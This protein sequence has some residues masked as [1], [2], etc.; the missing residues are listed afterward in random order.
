MSP[1]TDERPTRVELFIG[2]GG[3]GKTTVAC[4]TA[5]AHAAAGERVLLA[6]IDQAHSLADALGV[7][8]AHDPGTVAGIESVTDRVDVIEIDSLALL[9]DRFQGLTATLV[10]GAGHEHGFALDALDPAELTG[11]PGAQELLALN[12]VEVL[13]NE[14][15]WHTIVVDCGPS[16]DLLRTLSAPEMLLGYLERL[17]PRYER[18]AA[19]GRSDPRVAVVAA[20][21]ER[22]VADVEAVKALLGDRGRTTA[23]LVTAPERVALAEAA[24]TRSAA[25]LLGLRLAAVVV[26]KALPQLGKD[27]AGRDADPAAR[28]YRDRRREQLDVVADLD[29]QLA[30]MPVVVVGHTGPEPVGLARLGELTSAVAQ[31]CDAEASGEQEPPSTVRLESGSGVDSVYLLRMH[32]P[33]VDPTTLRLGR[34]AD[35][36]IVGVDG[37][38]GRVRLASVLRR[39]VVDGAE[40]AGQDLL[41]RFRPNPEVWPSE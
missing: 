4:A 8:I 9:E 34:A 24:R 17:W 7:T 1:P 19:I 35:D 13:A 21:V 36:L 16:A 30:G 31:L 14:N 20:T 33:L 12:E 37:V 15:T 40:L 2:K 5:L 10:A 27:D 29:T 25:A 23:C 39:C 22:I 38:R 3:V 6:S 11:L 41:V 32:L 26:N 18:V 28:W